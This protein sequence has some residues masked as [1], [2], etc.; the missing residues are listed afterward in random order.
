[1]QLG[2]SSAWDSLKSRHVHTRFIAIDL[3]FFSILSPFKLHPCSN[4]L[5]LML[6]TFVPI[7]EHVE[8]IASKKPVQRL[9]TYVL[10]SITLDS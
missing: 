2:I 10:L 3:S 6:T 7:V 4:T 9:S 8:Y 5:V 1:M